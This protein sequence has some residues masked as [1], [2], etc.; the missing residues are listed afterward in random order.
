MVKI[1][2]TKSSS[3]EGSTTSTAPLAKVRTVYYAIEYCCYFY[4]YSGILFFRALTLLDGGFIRILSCFG[5]FNDTV[6]TLLS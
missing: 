6:E 1:C 4:Y 2:Q 3:G 5:I